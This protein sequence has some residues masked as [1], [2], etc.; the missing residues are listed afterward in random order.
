MTTEITP[1]VLSARVASPTFP[2]RLAWLEELLLAPDPLRAWREEAAREPTDADDADRVEMAVWM[3]W[4]VG[5]TLSEED[6]RWIESGRAIPYGGRFRSRRGLWMR[7]GGWVR[8]GVLVRLALAFSSE[9][10]FGELVTR[11][12]RQFPGEVYTSEAMWVREGLKTLRTALVVRGRAEPREPT[13]AAPTGRPALRLIQGG[14]SGA[15]EEIQRVPRGDVPPEESPEE[16]EARR[17][18][19]EVARGVLAAIL[20]EGASLKRAR[21]NRVLLM[22]WLEH[23]EEPW[24]ERWDALLGPYVMRPKG[25][26]EIPAE[27]MEALPRQRLGRLA[28]EVE[29]A[30]ASWLLGFPEHTEALLAALE[31]DFD[32]WTAVSGGDSAQEALRTLRGHGARLL[33]PL[34]AHL[35]SADAWSVSAARLLRSVADATSLEVLLQMVGARSAEV[36]LEAARAVAQLGPAVALEAL[37]ARYQESTRAFPKGATRASFRTHA[38]V[39]LRV[40][41]W[42]G[43]EGVED[44]IRALAA[45]KKL[46][47]SRREELEAL[48]G[49][50]EVG[51]ALAVEGSLFQVC[52]RGEE[53]PEW[54]EDPALHAQ[55]VGVM[56]RELRPGEALTE[57]VHEGRDALRVVVAAL[58]VACRKGWRLLLY[59]RSAAAGAKRPE[60]VEALDARIREI[61]RDDIMPGVEGLY[62]HTTSDDP[63]LHALLLDRREASIRKRAVT[64]MSGLEPE[65]ALPALL[66]LLTSGRAATRQAAAECVVELRNQAHLS[67]RRLAGEEG[68]AEADARFRDQARRMGAL[69]ALYGAS[70]VEKNA[71]VRKVLQSAVDVCTPTRDDGVSPGD[72]GI[73][74]LEGDSMGDVNAILSATRSLAHGEP[75]RAAWVQLCD[76]LHRLHRVG[77]V[78]L[79]LDYLRGGEHPLARQAHCARPWGWEELEGLKEIGVRA[80]DVKQDAA[81]LPV[82]AF[83]DEATRERF[84]LAHLARLDAGERRRQLN[85]LVA[86]RLLLPRIFSGWAW[87][88]EHGLGPEAVSVR[89]DAGKAGKMARSTQVTS[90]RL[91]DG[92]AVALTREIAKRTSGGS[93]DTYL[94]HAQAHVPKGHALHHHPVLRNRIGHRGRL[95]LDPQLSLRGE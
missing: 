75:T 39:P 44:A 21:F 8:E 58:E 92:F 5:E 12:V 53:A 48:P 31:R 2:S 71:R 55:L 36:A 87:V 91:V 68:A 20:E 17:V 24:P 42:R 30:H 50:P 82:S 38:L 57:M 74:A 59:V 72:V 86:T 61:F 78:T 65:V 1:E 93:G 52:L 29:G 35:E 80:W 81:W 47:A 64:A 60:V 41:V 37:R 16:A 49:A 85:P 69:D 6:A 43:E 76:L 56:R 4:A 25:S 27:L 70:R 13:R 73:Y 15:G 19:A 90:L 94:V 77:Q 34:H 89:V 79:G 67:G 11:W 10:R 3:L 33:E 84:F 45:T 18:A 88:V 7:H 23:L 66:P 83:A 95:P 54:G 40:W 62:S 51:H 22:G 32:D 14:A 63:T 28:S 46:K 26:K 9:E